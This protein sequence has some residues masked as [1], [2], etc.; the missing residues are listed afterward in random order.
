MRT[1]IALLKKEYPEMPFTFS[2]TGEVNRDTLDKGPFHM[3]DFLE[4]HI[5]MTS[6]NGGEFYREV[7]YS[8]DLFS[9]DSY[10][11][12]ALHGERVYKERKAH[13]Q[14]ATL[15]RPTGEGRGASGPGRWPMAPRTER[16]RR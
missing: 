6:F 5:W 3:L 14:Q 2:F 15:S 12:L 10:Q 7:G 1:S 9:Y 8:F 11:N 4:P 16:Q 13:W